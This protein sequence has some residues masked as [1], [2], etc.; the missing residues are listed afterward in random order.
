MR[1]SH[2]PSPAPD[3]QALF[4]S[5]PGL[6][7]V[8]SPH[9]NIVAVSDSYLRATMTKREEILGRG[10]FEVFPDNPDDPSATGVRNLQTSLQRVLQDKTSDTMAV[11]K[12]DIRK[13]ESEGGE[14][15]ERYWSPV[16]SPVL[17]PDNIVAYIIHRV[18]DVTEFIRIKQQGLEWEV[19]SQLKRDPRT[20]H[21]PI[22]VVSIVDHPG[23]GALLG[24]DEYLVKPVDKV[25]L[26][27]ALERRLSIQ[28]ATAMAQPI[29]VVEDDVATREFIAELLSAHGYAVNTAADAAQARAKVAAM[30]PELVILDLLLPDASGFELLGEWRA[31]PQ[32]AEV[33]V[34]VLTSKELSQQEQHY[35]R[36]HAEALLRKQEPWQEALIKQLERVVS[37]G[38]PEKV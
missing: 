10:I 28:A 1:N 31:S 32:M 2:S 36:R 12:Y 13:P 37:L 24:A 8:L 17:G 27:D 23:M 34:F 33:P 25:T 7:L 26:L 21:I 14:F 29:L 20:A 11:Q 5:A 22:I 30:L 6:Y 18:E 9:L 15:E 38:P 19:L 16:N 35:L 4:Q 3:F